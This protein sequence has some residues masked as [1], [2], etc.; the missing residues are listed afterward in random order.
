MNEK[1]LREIKRRFNPEKSNISVIR[2]CLVNEKNE[3]VTQFSQSLALSNEDETQNL[4]SLLKKTLS[5]S[6]GANLIDIA[7]D[8]DDVVSG[9]EHGLLMKLKK[10]QLKD[11]EAVT[12][13]FTNAVSTLHFE[14]NYV[15]LLAND[16][17]D[18]FNY[19][20]DG[21]RE[22]DSSSSYSYIICAACPI[23]LTKPALSFTS[24]DNAFHNIAASSIVCAPS[25]GF[26]FPAFDDRRENIYNALMYTRD[27]TRQYSE[28]ISHIFKSTAP[29]PAAVQKVTFSSCLAET[30]AEECDFEV[31]KAVHSQINEM[32]EQHKT[33]KDDEP[34]VMTKETL[35]DVLTNGGVSEEKVE[36]FGEKF[37]EEFGENTLLPPKN[38]V[39][40]KNFELITPDVTIKVNPERAD[41][42][43][44]QVINGVEYILIRASEG[45]EVNG[46][47][48]SIKA[49][50]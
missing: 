25:L 13:F 4:L 31:V 6:L 42:V 19:T 37:D 35:K 1:E 24:S 38:L 20:S 17:Y 46:V 28:F 43:S 12:E 7:F 27:I 22:E 48:I 49:K 11:D 41:L 2:G 45:V 30:V 18:V 15:I 5:G 40:V 21:N 50:E 34:L 8:T 36:K 26:L 16:K 33:I 3:I 44:T 39:S 23:K 32:I 29:M 10:S 9:K 47:N 14:S